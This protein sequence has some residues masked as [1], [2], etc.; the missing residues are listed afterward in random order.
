MSNKDQKIYIF[1]CEP[2]LGE[3]I[4]SV[5]K[6]VEGGTEVL[7]RRSLVLMSLALQAK[8][9]G[10]NIAIIDDSNKIIDTIDGF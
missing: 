7:F 8:K 2:A 5:S 6:H 9:H 10:Y 3:L 1:T 4:D